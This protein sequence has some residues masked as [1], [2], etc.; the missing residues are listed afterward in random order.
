MTE[1]LRRIIS[2]AVCPYCDCPTRLVSG[3]EIYPHR[4]GETPRPKFL[5]KKYYVC[6]QNPDHYVGTYRDNV[7]SLGRLADQELRRL[8]NKG[9]RTFDPLWKNKTFFKSQTEAYQWLSQQMG[10]PRELTHF[11]MFSVEQCEE[12]IYL[13]EELVK[14]K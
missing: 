12:A 4:V 8:K 3:D 7:T 1:H 9:H 2:G 5:D 14:K 6:E 13:C 11:G 10:L